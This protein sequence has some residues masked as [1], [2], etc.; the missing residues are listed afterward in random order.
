MARSRTSRRVRREAAAR[1]ARRAPNQTQTVQES[2]DNP[3]GVGVDPNLAKGSTSTRTTRTSTSTSTSVTSGMTK[4]QR[5]ALNAAEGRAAAELAGDPSAQELY[6][7]MLRLSTLDKGEREKVLEHLRKVAE[8]NLSPFF[9]AERQEVLTDVNFALETIT[10]N[11]DQFDDETKREFRQAIEKLDY[12]SAIELR[13]TFTAVNQRN[14]LDSGMMA[15]LAQRVIDD[16]EFSAR[17]FKEDLDDDLRFSGEKQA[18]AEKEVGIGKDKEFRD[19]EQ[20]EDEAIELQATR[21]AGRLELEEILT[22]IQ[23]GVG[24]IDPATGEFRFTPQG[25]E[26][27]AVDSVEEQTQQT[28]TQQD[29][30]TTFNRDPIIQARTGETPIERTTLSQVRDPS[31]EIQSTEATTQEGQRL[32][33]AAEI[34]RQQRLAAS[35]AATAT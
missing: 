17:Q 20:Q 21:E 14:L 29:T 13:D 34:R 15:I 31:R 28:Q 11:F 10:Q 2:I 9:E 25:G 4:E 1:R 26:A 22:A 19:I 27:D 30:F 24:E 35:A 12:Q 8:E 16:Q 6:E 32:Q 33:S 23:D 3:R 7:N 18:L 5:A